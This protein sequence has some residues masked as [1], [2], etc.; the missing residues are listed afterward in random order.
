[1]AGALTLLIPRFGL[2][3]I[4]YSRMLPGC[5]T[6]LVYVPLADRLTKRSTAPDSVNRPSALEEV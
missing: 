6:L 4:A 3:G 2:A 1:M 5:V